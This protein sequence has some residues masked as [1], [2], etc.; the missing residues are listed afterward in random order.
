MS[1]IKPEL[2][3]AGPAAS[4]PPL[5]LSQ[6]S[7]PVLNHLLHQFVS[8]HGPHPEGGV[9]TTTLKDNVTQTTG[10]HRHRYPLQLGLLEQHALVSARVSPCVPGEQGDEL[11]STQPAPHLWPCPWGKHHG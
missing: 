6:Q 4:T 2:F 11:C 8:P 7:H 9:N 1:S 10:L 3:A 5:L